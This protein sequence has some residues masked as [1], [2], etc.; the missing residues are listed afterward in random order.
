MT[1]TSLS[2]LGL[3]AGW[4][5]QQVASPARLVWPLPGEGAVIEGQIDRI[6]AC[7]NNQPFVTSYLDAS[8]PFLENVSILEN[9]W[10]PLAWRRRV[11]PIELIRRAQRLLPPLGWDGDDLRRL[12]ACRPGDL[13]PAVLG[14]AV[15]LRAALANPD[16]LLIEPGWF[17]RP[18]LPPHEL[19]SLVQS[20]LGECRWLLLWPAQRQPLPSGVSWHTIPMEAEA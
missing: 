10:V 18:L 12:L 7:W 17:E 4:T 8:A 11:R 19:T 2:S 13:T 16:W 3:A 15:L 6:C 9:I 1:R 20:L 14:R 5:P